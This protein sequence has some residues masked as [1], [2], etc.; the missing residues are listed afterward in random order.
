MKG[1]NVTGDLKKEGRWA[2]KR[3]LR[4]ERKQKVQPKEKNEVVEI[5]GSSAGETREIVKWIQSR[6]GKLFPKLNS[7]YDNHYYRAVYAQRLYDEYK[8]KEKDIPPKERYIMRKERAGEVY[9]KQ[10]MEI[11][12][13]NLGHNRISVIAQSYLYN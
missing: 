3:R 1:V 4:K 8:R 10:A 12:S 9:D 5:C 7:N 2:E 6:Q 11:V 13:R